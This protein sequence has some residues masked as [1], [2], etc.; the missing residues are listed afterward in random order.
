MHNNDNAL[1]TLSKVSIMLRRA[2]GLVFVLCCFFSTLPFVYPLSAAP[3]AAREDFEHYL[4]AVAKLN[5][6]EMSSE[7][8]K[9]VGGLIWDVLRDMPVLDQINPHHNLQTQQLKPYA[10]ALK[11]LLQ[12]MDSTA[13]AG[14]VL[15]AG[16]LRR[17]QQQLG[18]ATMPHSTQMLAT[19][20]SGGADASRQHHKSQPA[21]FGA[22]LEFNRI[23]P[24]DIFGAFLGTAVP[25]YPSSQMSQ[26]GGDSTALGTFPPGG[27]AVG[28]PDLADSDGVYSTPGEIR[29]MFAANVVAAGPGI[30]PP[31]RRGVEDV[32]ADLDIDS[33]DEKRGKGKKVNNEGYVCQAFRQYCG[34]FEVSSRCFQH[35]VVQRGLW[36]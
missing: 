21:E 36:S 22:G 28:L 30:H 29:D 17:W 16:K 8:L 26:H 32:D 11:P 10:Q 12:H 5:G 4:Q 9:E 1:A 31:A 20:R 24:S 18:V 33:D 2:C 25:S 27:S 3:K 6:G 14:V 34:V 7:E 23:L 35:G 15:Q 19:V 13:L